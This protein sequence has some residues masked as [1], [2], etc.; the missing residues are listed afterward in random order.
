MDLDELVNL[1]R[2]QVMRMKTELPYTP[3]ELLDF[4]WLTFSQQITS[5]II[6]VA[7]LK[8]GNTPQRGEVSSPSELSEEIIEKGKM[9]DSLIASGALTIMPAEQFDELMKDELGPDQTP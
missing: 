2:E 3:V 5:I 7:N 4:K 6:D 8:A 1:G 9:L